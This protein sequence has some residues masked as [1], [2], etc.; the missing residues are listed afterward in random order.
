MLKFVTKVFYPSSTFATYSNYVVVF[1]CV[2]E[3]RFN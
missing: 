2:V 1:S 3:S